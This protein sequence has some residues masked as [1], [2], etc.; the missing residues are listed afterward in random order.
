MIDR[1]EVASGGKLH[2]A[3]DYLGLFYNP[4]VRPPGTMD[5]STTPN[6]P[7]PRNEPESETSPPSESTLALYTINVLVWEL[8]KIEFYGISTHS[9]YC[10]SYR[11][12]QIIF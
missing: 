12:D 11:S 9:Q 1:T 8:S 10:L 2:R 6:T 5:T 4:I 3:C 7:P